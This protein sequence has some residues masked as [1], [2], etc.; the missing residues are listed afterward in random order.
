[1]PLRPLNSD[2]SLTQNLSQATDMFRE[3]FD[4]QVTEIFKDSAG[5]RR[6]LLGKGANGFYGLKVSKA[7]QDVYTATDSQLVFNSGQDIFKIVA[8]VSLSITALAT[9]NNITTYAHGLGYVPAVVGFLNAGLAGGAVRTP[10]PTWT[11]L[12]R[13]DINHQVVFRTWIN[14]EADA[15]NLYIDFF[16][17][18]AGTVGPLTVTVYL[19]QETAN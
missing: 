3:L 10:L 11:S 2:N 19:L 1:M 12:T 16:N 7:G 8:V 18:T 4:R 13:D 14:A 17:S 9:T 6:V 5:V 15:T